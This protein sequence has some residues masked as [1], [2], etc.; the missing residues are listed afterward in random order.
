MRKP[1]EPITLHPKQKAV[2]QKMILD[3]DVNAVYELSDRKRLDPLSPPLKHP[4][5]LE[6]GASTAPPRG[7]TTEFL[8]IE[9][10]MREVRSL[11]ERVSRLEKRWN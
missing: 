8:D 4:D 10:I 1:Y 9:Q 5:V 2:Y 7:N 3:S 6:P 11:R